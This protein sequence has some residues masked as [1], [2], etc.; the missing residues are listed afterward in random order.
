M[1]KNTA[2]EI[3]LEIG[4]KKTFACAVNWPGWCR[5]GKDEEAAIQTLLQSAPRYRRMLESTPIKFQLP[6]RVED[7]RVVEHIKGDAST[8]FGVPGAIR[9]SDSDPVDG[10][11]AKRYRVILQAAWDSFDQAVQTAQGIELR[12]GPRGGGRELGAIIEHVEGADAGYLTRIGRKVGCGS[13][14]VT[15]RRVEQARNQILRGIE[16]GEDVQIPTQG[17]RGGK[18]WPLR[19]Y[20]RRAAWHVIDHAWEI[21]DRLT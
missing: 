13:E 9:D 8:D 19:Y 14:P 15:R 17:P 3:Y 16:A 1:F 5:A 6:T 12:K 21:E 7:L 2:H 11:E 18:M 4:K 10:E 20:A